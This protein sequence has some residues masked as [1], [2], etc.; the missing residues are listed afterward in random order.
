M[1]QTQSNSS[2]ASQRENIQAT[3]LNIQKFYPTNSKIKKKSKFVPCAIGRGVTKPY[4][5]LCTRW[6]YGQFEPTKKIPPQ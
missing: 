1:T 3:S 5:N 2:F 6:K 4:T